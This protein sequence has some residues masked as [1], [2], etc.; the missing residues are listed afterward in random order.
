M[1]TVIIGGGVVGLSTAYHL[2][3]KKAGEVVILEKGQV[4]DGASSRAAG[5]YNMLGWHEPGIVT[6]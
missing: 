3:Q 5:I 6:R 4:G 1:K 2:A